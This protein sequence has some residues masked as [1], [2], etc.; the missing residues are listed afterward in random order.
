MAKFDPCLL[1]ACAWP[2]KVVKYGGEYYLQY[3]PAKAERCPEPDARLEDGTALLKIPRPAAEEL[4]KYD[5]CARELLEK[6]A[7]DGVVEPPRRGCE[8]AY[9]VLLSKLKALADLDKDRPA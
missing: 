9:A 2:Y 6:I 8:C 7:V 3:I 4:E 1:M 5:K